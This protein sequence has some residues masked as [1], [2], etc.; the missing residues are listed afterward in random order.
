[1]HVLVSGIC[2]TSE[3][4]CSV[5]ATCADA[6]HGSF[7]CTCDEGYTGDGKTCEGIRLDS[8]KNRWL[9]LSHDNCQNYLHALTQHSI[10][11]IFS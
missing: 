8:F 1:M 7:T 3:D 4:D 5:F 2:G 10:I 6:D 11:N 9:P